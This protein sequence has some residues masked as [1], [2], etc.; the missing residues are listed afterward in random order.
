MT[1]GSIFRTTVLST[2][3][4]PLSYRWI[5]HTELPTV[6][7]MSCPTFFIKP[8]RHYR[9][10]LN[11]TNLCFVFFFLFT[12]TRAVLCLTDTGGYHWIDTLPPRPTHPCNSATLFI[13]SSFSWYINSHHTEL[14]SCPTTVNSSEYFNFK[15]CRHFTLTDCVSYRTSRAAS[16]SF[17]WPI[18]RERKARNLRIGTIFSTTCL[19]LPLLLLLL[20]DL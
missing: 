10:L 14:I 13:Q 20:L 6:R 15:Y 16:L 19:L 17:F 18:I 4:P 12:W 7:E 2:P 11:E 1:S 8:T 9:R 5:M 3:A